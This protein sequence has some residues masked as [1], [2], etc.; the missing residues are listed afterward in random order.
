MKLTLASAI[1]AA[2]QKKSFRSGLTT[3]TILNK[4]MNDA[5][6]MINLL[7]NLLF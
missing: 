6:K 3:Y 2:I 7:N 5:M 4:E 1:D